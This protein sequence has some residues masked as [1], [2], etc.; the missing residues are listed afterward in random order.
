MLINIEAN[1]YY[2]IFTVDPNPFISRK[3][4]D[5]NSHKVEKVF[6]L[7]E[8]HSKPSIGI[9][10]GLKDSNLFCPFSAP[11]GG[12]HFRNELLCVSTINSFIENLKCFIKTNGF[13]SIQIVLPPNIYHQTFDAKLINC[14]YNEGFKV[15][16]PDIT[17]WVNLESFDNKFSQKRTTESLKQAMKHGLNFKILT[18]INEKLEAYELIMCNRR[19]FG[20]PLYM[21]FKDLKEINN[22]WDIDYFVVNDGSDSILASAIFYRAHKSI[23]Y[24]V[25]WGDNEKGRALGVMNFFLFNLWKHYKQ[26]GFKYIDI[27]ISSVEGIP[28]EGLLRF[29][30]M[31]EAISSLRYTF[32]W[33][34][35]TAV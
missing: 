25:F 3:F 10:A 33:T 26:S 4:I 17:S 34:N 15:K 8:D 29:K 9:I 22:I 20:R 23:V 24:A 2:N 28:N 11:F 1:S 5:I 27:S 6:M 12:F 16:T 14:L 32:T 13:N 19:Q 35:D 31:H 7:V 30:E 21:T 18:Q